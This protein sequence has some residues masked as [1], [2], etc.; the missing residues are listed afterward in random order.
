MKSADVWVVR[1]SP[2]EPGKLQATSPLP[3][4]S[5]SGPTPSLSSAMN[6]S[7][8][9]TAPMIVLP[10]DL[11]LSAAAHVQ[12]HDAAVRERTDLDEVAELVAQP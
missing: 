6:P 5:N 12:A 1:D 4:Q 9:T 7:S 3:N 2:S 8:E 11:V 10:M